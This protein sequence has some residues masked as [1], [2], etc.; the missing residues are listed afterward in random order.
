MTE[1][2]T[3]QT[4]SE[5]Y[6]NTSDSD[7]I[8]SSVFGAEFLGWETELNFTTRQSEVGAHHIR[9]PGGIV[10]EDGIDVDGDGARDVVYDLSYENVMSWN[11][12]NGQMREGLS[13]VLGM[14]NENEMSFS[15]L[16][17]TSRYVQDIIDLSY[18][19]EI[20]DAR[21]L[22]LADL[23]NEVLSF[24]HRLL[25]G[26]Y[27]PIPEDFTFEVGSEYYATE[28]WRNNSGPDGY[29]ELPY[30]F[31]LVFATIS[32]AVSDALDGSDQEIHI[33]VQSGRFQ[34]DDD[35]VLN[36]DGQAS[37]NDYFIQ[38][39]TDLDALDTVEAL[40]YH[41]YGTSFDN[42]DRVAAFGDTT[43]SE[44]LSEAIN[45]WTQATGNNDINLLAG[46]LTPG[47]GV[48]GNESSFSSIE[49]GAPGLTSILQQFS[50]L[51]DSGMDVGTI[52]AL[53]YDRAGSLGTSWRSGEFEQGTLFVG[54]QLFGMMAESLVG[55]NLLEGYQ[56]NTAPTTWTTNG[57][58]FVH[59]DSV[60]S[61]VF[62]DDS[63]IVIFLFA[64]D[65]QGETLEYVVSI[66]QAFTYAWT[67]SLW[68]PDGINTGFNNS[69]IG[70]VG[71]IE[72]TGN[73][74]LI[75][76]NVS[77]EFTVT[78]ENE[79]EVIRIILAREE[80]GEGYL[81]LY[82]GETQ[83]ILNGG[84]S[85]DFLQGNGGWDILNGNAGDDRL[86]GGWGWDVI[87]GG[88]GDDIIDGGE[89]DDHLFGNE[90][91]DWIIGGNGN[92][93]VDGGAGNDLLEGGLGND[94]FVFGPSSSSARI[95]D[96]NIEDD[97]IDLQ[98]FL[99][100]QDNLLI[101]VGE[102]AFFVSSLEATQLGSS[103]SLDI[104]LVAGDTV[105]TLRD[106]SGN[107]TM[108]L[109]LTGI[110]LPEDPTLFLSR[111][112]FGENLTYS[113]ISSGDLVLS[114]FWSDV[115]ASAILRYELAQEVTSQEVVLTNLLQQDQFLVTEPVVFASGDAIFHGTENGDLIRGGEATDYVFAGSGNDYV[116][117]GGGQDILMMNEGNDIAFGRG[118]H[119]HIA[120][121]SGDDILYGGDG[122][123]LLMG[124]DGNDIIVGGRGNDAMEGGDGLDVFVF[125]SHEGSNED[126]IS[127]FNSSEDTI[128]IYGSSFSELVISSTDNDVIVSWGDNSIR[129]EGISVSDLIE[130]DFLF[131]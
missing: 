116:D 122:S 121:G 78:F 114:P 130:G 120:G 58:V 107:I 2:L 81:H 80:P 112:S 37:D 91:D 7:G 4:G 14:A 11:R 95:T 41:R 75:T 72:S 70:V 84:A 39:F 10:A 45:S 86:E 18:E 49:H 65:F 67:Q 55:T 76:D 125:F 46:W 92:D 30:E 110:Y 99:G 93:I 54:G 31:G 5:H 35:G 53:G 6:S 63:K 77:T 57:G 52:F 97:I 117:G 27:G 79:Y 24:V 16:L 38:A 23:Y 71:T 108:L 19:M 48:D 83:D 61:Y 113:S 103:Y 56:N 74:D 69:N 62:E 109:E 43:L 28:V 129:F 8:S 127:D 124:G 73:L 126:Y 88:L 3:L 59:D 64:K 29:S 119:D 9:W 33:A 131:S 21:D 94:R 128:L 87:N 123:D 111:L 32:S 60:N 44:R 40:I 106:F 22:V 47:T 26:E 115:T 15:M 100:D 36:I 105:L 25:N 102:E 13:D 42:I 51:I 1:T 66:D 101:T 104:S 17:P 12:H 50:V 85:G 82:G 90:G 98:A 34:S 89:G 96:F 20:P 68:D 118:G